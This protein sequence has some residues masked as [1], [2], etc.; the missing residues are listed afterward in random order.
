[1]DFPLIHGLDAKVILPEKNHNVVKTTLNNITDSSLISKTWELRFCKEYA[2][3]YSFPTEIRGTKFSL[4]P[5]IVS[6]FLFV[7]IRCPL[8]SLCLLLPLP[9]S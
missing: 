8:Q 2:F 3:Y 7:S 4:G 6:F 1:M 9:L 5:K